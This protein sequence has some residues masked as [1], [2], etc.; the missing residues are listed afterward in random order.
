MQRS[1]L[2]VSVVL[3]CSCVVAQSADQDRITKVPF[4]D[5]KSSFA[6]YA[7]YIQVN[8]A[9]NR[10]LFYWFVESQ[11]SPQTDPVVLWMNGG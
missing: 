3:L 1:F 5:G 8:A 7:G 4:F 10:N 9:N 2:F 6:Q 11:S